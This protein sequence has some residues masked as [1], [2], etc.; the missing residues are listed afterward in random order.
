MGSGGHGSLLP[1]ERSELAC[2]TSAQSRTLRHTHAY[3]QLAH[4]Y[5]HRVSLYLPSAIA[6]STFDSSPSA[7]CNMHYGSRTRKFLLHHLHVQDRE[8][9]MMSSLS[10]SL[11]YRMLYLACGGVAFC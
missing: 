11:S 4:S 3:T 10:S 5:T 7:I 9:I 6:H 2:M 8:L 1:E